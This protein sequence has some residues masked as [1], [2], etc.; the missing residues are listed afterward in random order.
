M[1]GV[2]VKDHIQ[3]GTSL[4]FMS[5]LFPKG[6]FLIWRRAVLPFIIVPL[7]IVSCAAAPDLKSSPTFSAV[8]EVHSPTP[9]AYYY[10]LLGSLAEL[11]RH[12]S[13]AFPNYEAALREDPES[14]Y[15]RVRL[16]TLYFSAGKMSA[17]LETIDP[18]SQ[19]EIHHVSTLLQMA[20]IYAG[21]GQQEKALTAYDQAI[22]L[23]PEVQKIYF[24]KGILL[25]NLQRYE[26]A[27]VALERGNALAP[28]SYVGYFYLGKTFQKLGEIGQATFNFEKALDLSPRFAPA[29]QAFATMLEEQHNFSGAVEI[30]ERYLSR[31]N[32]HKKNFRQEIVRLHLAQGSYQQAL[33]VLKA[34]VVDDPADLN[35]QVR[36]ALIYGEIGDHGKAIEQLTLILDTRPGEVRVRDYLGLMYEEIQDYEPAIQAYHESIDWEP[37]FYDSRVHL[38]YLLYRLK[39]YDDA[40]PQLKEAVNLNPGSPEPHVLLGMAYLQSEQP[41]LALSA[42]EY[43]IDLHPN[44]SD[45]RFN[46]GAAYDKVNRFPDVVR[47]MEKVLSLDPNHTDALNYLGYSYADRGINIEQAVEL[48]QRA[49][50]LK[51]ENGY[52]V[53]SFGWALFKIG[54]VDDALNEIERA[55]GL[56]KD[57]PVIYEHLGEI[58]LS[59]ENREQAQKAW[60]RSL[61]LDPQNTDLRKRFNEEGFGSSVLPQEKQSSQPQVRYYS[62][63]EFPVR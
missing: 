62:P 37:T 23:D 8:P 6:G 43:G 59:Q 28:S 40:I 22:V 52:Y 45:L 48:T 25:F 56:V 60:S 24:S 12:S 30:Y 36:I 33:D 1:G 10:F 31:V 41:S 13:Q 57:D 35:A 58:Y 46:L 32:P 44:N 29:Y 61:E 5:P 9:K 50:S 15:L 26:E 3:Q 55:L 17:A 21:A 19:V 11:S 39:R 18:L 51:P 27:R 53:D 20:R 38:G 63:E 4:N 7:M 54:R 49:V 34:L 16:G 47:E 2:G 42:F 14:Q